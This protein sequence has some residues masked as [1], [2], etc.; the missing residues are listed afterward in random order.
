MWFIIYKNRS[1]Q[2]RTMTNRER[3]T[4][5]TFQ[6]KYTFRTDITKNHSNEETINLRK[7]TK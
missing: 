6:L 2:S 1:Q 4:P 7:Y 3:A 5:I